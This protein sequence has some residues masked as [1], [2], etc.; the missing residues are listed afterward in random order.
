MRILGIGDYN[1]LGSIYMHLAREGH[2]VRVHIAEEGSR[3]VRRGL[4]PQANDW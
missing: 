2:D 1:D 4:V 3:D